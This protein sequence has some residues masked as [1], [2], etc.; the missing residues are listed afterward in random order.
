MEPSCRVFSVLSSRLQTTLSPSLD[1]VVARWG[2]RGF[3]SKVRGLRLEEE[4]GDVCSKVTGTERRE[5]R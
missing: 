4:A 2:P 3:G 5:R 1:G